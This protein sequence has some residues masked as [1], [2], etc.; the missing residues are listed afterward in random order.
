[1]FYIYTLSKPANECWQLCNPRKDPVQMKERLIIFIK[2]PILG[3]VK[4]RIA[5]TTGNEAALKI[6]KK[7]LQ[8]THDVA[9][10]INCERYVYYSDHIDENDGWENDLFEKRVQVQGDLGERMRAAFADKFEGKKSP[11]V[12]IGSDCIDLQPKHILNAFA[13]LKYNDSVI[14]PAMDGGYYLL[15]MNKM[16]ESVFKIKEWGTDT[17]LKQTFAALKKENL[18]VV[19]LQELN[20]IDEEKDVNFSY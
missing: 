13:S 16:H 12:I 19:L 4:T 9:V 8:H 7:L 3:K 17:V 15:G 10:Q 14:G 18:E 5:A 20:D 11:V 1:M 2:N 6:Y